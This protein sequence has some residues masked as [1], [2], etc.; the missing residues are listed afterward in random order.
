M[1]GYGP[2]QPIG[3]I[4]K[5]I[6]ISALLIAIVFIAGGT[7]YYSHKTKYHT[8]DFTRSMGFDPDVERPISIGP[9]ITGT[10]G[11]GQGT[12]GFLG[13]SYSQSQSLGRAMNLAVDVNGQTYVLST[14]TGEISF[15][16]VVGQE[17]PTVH[18]QLS[19]QVETEI[20]CMQSN[21]FDCLP[22][23]SNYQAAQANLGNFISSRLQNVAVTLSPQDL[24]TF[25]SS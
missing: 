7:W 20:V 6:A 19:N 21:D 5:V 11:S 17:T 4:R 23:N 25:I 14:P 18:F 12:W 1:W 2:Y 9:S 10:V 24:Q 15:N 13:G 22:G 16:V 3:P 8:I